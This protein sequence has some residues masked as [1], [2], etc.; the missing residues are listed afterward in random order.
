[1]I[2]QAPGAHCAVDGSGIMAAIQISID[3][4]QNRHHPTVMECTD[5]SGGLILHISFTSQADSIAFYDSITMTS[6][7][8][9]FV[10]N[11]RATG[12]LPCN[13]IIG[14][15][16]SSTQR[17]TQFSCTPVGGQAAT[18]LPSLCCISTP[19]PPPVPT[20][21]PVPFMTPTPFPVPT[22]TPVLV[23]VPRPTPVPTPAVPTHTMWFS[24]PSVAPNAHLNVD[25]TVQVLCPAMNNTIA[26]VLAA[27]GLDFSSVMMTSTL[28]LNGCAVVTPLPNRA[29]NNGFARIAYKFWFKI[30]PQEWALVS[31]ALASEGA[32]REG[33]V[34]CDSTIY[35]QTYSPDVNT[36]PPVSGVTDP[37]LLSQAANSVCYNDVFAPLH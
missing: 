4:T 1:M 8:N 17:Q 35:W 18:I 28:Q 16:E 30:S 31:A 2:V 13:A 14:V 25:S 26:L 22:P 24:A 19:P 20:A 9:F 36:R 10:F 33:H 34:M 32:I 23:P 37:T 6:G 29:V 11:A 7:M 15:V 12:D 5:V 27:Y 21:T 3:I